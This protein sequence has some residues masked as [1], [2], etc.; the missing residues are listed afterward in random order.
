MIQHNNSIQSKRSRSL[1]K[2]FF[3]DELLATMLWSSAG[4]RLMKIASLY[5]NLGYI[6]YYRLGILINLICNIN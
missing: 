3:F 2:F 4:T 5:T 6:T 1:T